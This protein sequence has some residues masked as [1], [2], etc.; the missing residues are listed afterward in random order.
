M[1]DEAQGFP[2]VDPSLVAGWIPAIASRSGT[3]DGVVPEATAP[4]YLLHFFDVVPHNLLTR[5]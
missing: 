3:L 5:I 2:D 4:V 1:I